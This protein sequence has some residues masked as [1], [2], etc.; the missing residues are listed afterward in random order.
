MF[1]EPSSSIRAHGHSWSLSGIR[2]LRMALMAHIEDRW[3]RADRQTGRRWRVRYLDPAGRV[4]VTHAPAAARLAICTL[5][6]ILNVRHQGHPERSDPG[7]RP[8][9]TMGSDAARWLSE[10]RRSFARCR[11]A[12]EMPARLHRMRWKPRT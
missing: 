12:A 8:R 1:G 11:R 3:K 9:M 7:E 4:Q 2:S 10:H 6:P 5:P